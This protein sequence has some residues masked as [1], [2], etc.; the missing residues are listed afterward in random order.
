MDKQSHYCIFD[1]FINF[2]S[3]YDSF[4]VRG[5]KVKKQ[6]KEMRKRICLNF[7]L[8]DF[9]DLIMMLFQ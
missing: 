5:N 9:L 4:L 7:Y 3:L 6:K 8:T 2:L 1:C